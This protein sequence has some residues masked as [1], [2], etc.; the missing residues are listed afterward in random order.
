MNNIEK[1]IR[2]SNLALED[3]IRLNDLYNTKLLESLSGNSNFISI[4]E[5]T[6]NY[7]KPKAELRRDAEKLS[8]SSDSNIAKFGK[9]VLVFLAKGAKAFDSLCLAIT[10]ILTI[11][12]TVLATCISLIIA[13]ILFAVLVVPFATLT[14]GLDGINKALG[15]VTNKDKNVTKFKK[16][17]DNIQSQK[18][19]IKD[20]KELEKLIKVSESLEYIKSNPE[21]IPVGEALNNYNM[22]NLLESRM[23]EDNDSNLAKLSIYENLC[24]DYMTETMENST[25]KYLSGKGLFNDII[26]I[27]IDECTKDSILEFLDSYKNTVN[28]ELRNNNY[29]D[30]PILMETGLCLNYVKDRCSDLPEVLETCNKLDVIL[31]DIITECKT[32]ISEEVSPQFNPDPLGIGSLTPFPVGDR[33][34]SNALCDIDKAE[35]DEEITEAMINLGRI[36]NVI[37]ENYYVMESD[38]DYTIV[39]ED[40]AKTARKVETKANEKFAKKATKDKSNSVKS[41]VKHAIDPMEKWVSNQYK[42]LKEKDENERRK[43]IMSGGDPTP[44][45][46]RWVKRGIVVLIGGGIGTVIPV[47][48]LITGITLIGWIHT[49]KSLDRKTRQKV[50]AELDDEIQICNEKIDDAKG[51]DDKKK[52]YEL[53]RI[54]NTLER[55]RDKIKFNLK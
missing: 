45:I 44:K 9:A 3:Y 49:D 32:S 43:I 25:K 33:A 20:I 42:K 26:S 19:G 47:S 52:K 41:A 23:G 38:N 7:V 50:M 6:E 22:L 16:L 29:N 40:V 13:I 24:P 21:L 31:G 34:V 28:Y 36:A 4:Y 1:D 55:Q 48:A 53:M 10:S 15:K 12:G 14:A 54:R 18:D 27:S 2:F 46:L 11:G 5:S 51:A 39:E 37:R 8:K 35:T 17:S 30:L